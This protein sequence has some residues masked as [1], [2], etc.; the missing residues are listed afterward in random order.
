[1]NVHLTLLNDS[2]YL[3]HPFFSLSFFSWNNHCIAYVTAFFFSFLVLVLS[4]E[5]VENPSPLERPV[6]PNL[7]PSRSQRRRTLHR[8]TPRLLGK[9]REKRHGYHVECCDVSKLLSP[10]WPFALLT[11]L[12]FPFFFFE[13]TNICQ[14]SVVVKMKKGCCWHCCGVDVCVA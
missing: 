3:T 6:N 1:M 11:W 7:E 8:G 12:V 5:P 10:I 2:L 13:I 4:I 14:M 9:K